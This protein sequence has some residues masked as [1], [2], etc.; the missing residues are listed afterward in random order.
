MS[1]VLSLVKEKKRKK[2]N[3]V[4]VFSKDEKWYVV[5]SFSEV[6][7]GVLLIVK[8]RKNKWFQK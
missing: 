1:Q 3:M 8:K 5:E 4:K 7:N 2:A 6:K